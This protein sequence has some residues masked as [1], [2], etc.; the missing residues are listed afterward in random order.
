MSWRSLSL[1]WEV[2]KRGLSDGKSPNSV[3]ILI[4]SL[5]RESDVAQKKGLSSVPGDPAASIL[6]MISTIGKRY[7]C[8]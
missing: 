5:D 2:K 6:P 4:S 1:H 8:M 7:Y 3:Q